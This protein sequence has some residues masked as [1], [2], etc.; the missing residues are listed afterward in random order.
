MT[1]M[2]KSFLSQI[3][4]LVRY[5]AL[6]PVNDI[7]VCIGNEAGD[8]DSIISSTCY[9][10]LK[11]AQYNL[12]VETSDKIILPIISVK[13][14]EFSLRPDV[15]SL[16]EHV[17]I[18]E[19]CLI[20]VDELSLN[21]NIQ[22]EEK[23]QYILLDHNSIKPK[24]IPFIKD[25]HSIPYDFKVAEILDHHKDLNNH[26]SC[27]GFFRQIAFNP[28]TEKPEVGSTC[29]L[30]CEIFLSQNENLLDSTIATLLMG[31]IS[32]DTLNMDPLAEKG[33]ERDANALKVL[34]K[35][36][37]FNLYENINNAR[38]SVEFWQTLSAK[39]ALKLDYKC[40]ETSNN[41]SIG[42]SSILIPILSFIE[43]IDIYESVASYFESGSCQF[44]LVLTSYKEE[45]EPSKRQ[46]MIF[47]ST[48]DDLND[49]CNKLINREMSSMVPDNLKLGLQSY[50]LDSD[51]IN[52]MGK[53]GVF[54]QAFQQLNTILTR[55]QLCPIVTDLFR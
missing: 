36:S 9:A 14:D 8:A 7:F 40:F 45:K 17:G 55:K 48:S 2:I 30:V 38:R 20:C 37:P 12:N 25:Y 6:P 16:L 11:Q 31:V 32:L 44:L 19:R 52:R 28:I 51:Y 49:I 27:S 4:S 50:Q 53:K 26:I 35:I 41:L 15:I 39:N 33:T 46:I 1:K 22:N 23:L 3:S 5:H 13:R 21:E 43:K 24:S 47:S 42:M 34:E 29:T 54:C 10:Y 18:D